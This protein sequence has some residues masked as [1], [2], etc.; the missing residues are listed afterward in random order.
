MNVVY[1]LFPLTYY[2]HMPSCIR[3]QQTTLQAKIDEA[4]KGDTIE[5][6]EGEYEETINHL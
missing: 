4:S 3:K 1:Y 6:E 2:F 5:I